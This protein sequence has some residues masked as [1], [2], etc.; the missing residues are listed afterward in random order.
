[1]IDEDVLLLLSLLFLLLFLPPFLGVLS[2]FF[3]MMAMM[4]GM[5]VMTPSQRDVFLD[6]VHLLLL[7]RLGFIDVD[8]IGSRCVLRCR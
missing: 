5:M 8:V 6:V 2:F 4:V 3:N 1:M 7:L